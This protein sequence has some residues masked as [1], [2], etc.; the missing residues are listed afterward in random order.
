MIQRDFLESVPLEEL[1]QGGTSTF[2]ELLERLPYYSW[3]QVFPP[4]TGSAEKAPTRSIVRIRQAISSRSH[5]V[6]P[7]ESDRSKK[8]FF[9]FG[10]RP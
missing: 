4:R 7:H 5:H 2:D 9:L 1:T 8:H 10:R 3:N 6:H